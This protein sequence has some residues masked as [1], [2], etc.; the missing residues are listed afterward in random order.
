MPYFL[1]TGPYERFYPEIWTPRG[2][3]LVQPGDIRELDEN[4]GDGYW[5]DTPAPASVKPAALPS[6]PPATAPATPVKEA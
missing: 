6:G 5:E 1:Y 4:P 3:L 2:S